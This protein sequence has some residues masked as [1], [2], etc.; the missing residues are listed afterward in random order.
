MHLY[1]LKFLK[2]N[3]C[4]KNN[5]LYRRFFKY[6]PFSKFFIKILKQKK[7]RLKIYTLNLKRK[8]YYHLKNSLLTKFYIN[9]R[10]RSL[11]VS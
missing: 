7:R 3:L 4:L 9:K 11:K 2:I 6:K 1:F 10:I 5:K 8:F